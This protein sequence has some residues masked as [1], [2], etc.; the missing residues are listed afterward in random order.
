[1]LTKKNLKCDLCVIGG[2]LSGMCVAIAA[3]REGIKVVLMHERP[4]LGGNASS[5]IRMW[6]SG[7]VGEN[8]RETGIIEEI[9]LENMY[10]N[11]T[12]NFSIW[13]TVLYGIVKQEKNI[14]LLLN[15]TC[16]QAEVEQ[17]E[18]AY[19]RD[20]KIKSITGYQM[21]TQCFYEVQAKYYCDSSGDSILAPLCGAQ[22]R[23]GREAASEFN[24]RT[25]VQ[26]A[27]TMTMGM[28]CLLQARETNEK[29]LFTPPDWSLVLTGKD[30]ENR[31]LDI[32]FEGQNFW[33]LELGGNRN[34]I[35][36]TEEIRDDL[37]SLAIGTWSY[38]KNSGIYN[39]D[40]WDLDF[41]GFL[42][43]KRESR[44]M[45][46][47]YLLTQKDVSEG[48][49]FP[50]EV[51]YGGWPLDD[52]YPG[53]FYHRGAPNEHIPTP[54]PYSIPYR[55]L[56]SKNVDNLLFAGRNISATHTAMSSTRV[57]G[58]C[59]LLG[60]AVGKAVAVATRKGFAPHDVY[61]YEMEQVQNML[62]SEGC[63][64]P[65]KVRAISDICKNA[66]LEGANED[67]RN[68]RDR[69]HVLYADADKEIVTAS[70]N[71]P[72]RYKFSETRV[73]FV[74]ITFDSDIKRSTLEG[75]WIERE[76][77]M[78]AMRKLNSPQ[79]HMPT[80]LCKEFELIGKRKGESRC[81]LSVKINRKRNYH[82]AVN[83]ILDE[84]VLIPKAT[85][86]DDKKV[87]VISFD[88]N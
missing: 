78:R 54:A 32:Y 6:I 53:G 50:D 34:T 85:W 83:E 22:Y 88:F 11:P 61:L 35:D 14:T 48:K 27:D 75:G 44:R 58:T 20:R 74:H 38:I 52:H 67:V 55:A 1:M 3:A 12:K 66:I 43:G 65:S 81:L 56:Y 72:I 86:G 30:F 4:M 42:P 29:I 57:M 46:G 68:G 76:R 39:A 10:R 60:E 80:T 70:E 73:N 79:L 5:E 36:D 19:N 51:A 9:E 26:V 33:Y 63:F 2:G 16:M 15:C 41:I 69:L 23:L 17:G 25:T 62:M 7:C 87:P 8:N 18:Y 45:I 47:E 64:L 24:E 31:D 37:I 71:N 21:T 84:L 28:S 49:I 40:A 13:D 59:A 82:I 77:S